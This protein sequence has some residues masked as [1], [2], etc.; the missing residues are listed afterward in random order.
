[1]QKRSKAAAEPV[2][3]QPRED[4]FFCQA[5]TENVSTMYC[6]DSFVD[7]NALNIKDSPCFKCTQGAVVRDEFSNK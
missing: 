1:V 2:V 3:E 7:V 6:I 4:F 5:R